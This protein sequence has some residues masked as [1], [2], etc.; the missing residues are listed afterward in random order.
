MPRLTLEEQ[1]AK[2]QTEIE[3]EKEKLRQA[4]NRLQQ[5]ESREKTKERN[6]G[7]QRHAIVGGIAVKYFP[8]LEK[9]QP[10]RTKAEEYIEFAPW[11]N[12][13]SKLAARLV[14]DKEL[15]AYLF[16]DTP[17]TPNHLEKPVIE[18]KNQS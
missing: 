18:A 14:I 5:L 13:C 11:A 1:R 17:T 8:H 10:K 15:E 6:K 16:S 7:R 2:L 9:L 3:K 4:E 12:F